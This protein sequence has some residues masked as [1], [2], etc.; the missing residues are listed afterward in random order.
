MANVT[1]VGLVPLMPTL[2]QRERGPVGESLATLVANKL[3]LTRMYGFVIDKVGVRFELCRTL[4]ATERTFIGV[5][6]LVS[7]Q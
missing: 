6:Q 7:L 2:M 4:T 3:F 5:D 1:T